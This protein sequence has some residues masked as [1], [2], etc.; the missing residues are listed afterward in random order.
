MIESWNLNNLLKPEIILLFRI[1]AC[2][3]QR[4]GAILGI[5]KNMTE[6]SRKDSYLQTKCIIL[7]II[8]LPCTG[9][10]APQTIP[11][12]TVG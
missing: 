9:E 3:G 11:S 10:M 2:N 1:F 6:Q 5:S 8:I 4:S 7:C 12:V